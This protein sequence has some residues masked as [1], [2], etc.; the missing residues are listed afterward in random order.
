MCNDMCIADVCR[1]TCNICPLQCYSCP[2]TFYPEE[3]KLTKECNGSEVCVAM[4]E[5]SLDFL[6]LYYSDCM[7]KKECLEIFGGINTGLNK[8]STLIQKRDYA[9]N[10]SCCDHDFCN[11]HD[12]QKTPT[13]RPNVQIRPTPPTKDYGNACGLEDKNATACALIKAK[14]PYMCNKSCFSQFLCPQTCQK[15]SKSKKVVL[16]EL[17]I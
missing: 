10:G 14:D 16:V 3:C 12:P 13:E 1:R 9:L 6:P 5:L 15:C 7:T 4:Q 11:Q 17:Y 8:R 2:Q